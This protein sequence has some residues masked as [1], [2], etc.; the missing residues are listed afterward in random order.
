MACKTPKGAWDILKEEFG[1]I[2]KIKLLG[3][4]LT[5]KR[6]V[7][8]VLISLPERFEAKISSLEDSKNLSQI[9]LAELVHSL[10]AQEQRGL[11]RQEDSHDVAMVASQKGRVYQREDKKYVGEKKGK[12][13]SIYQGGKRGGMRSFPP[14]SHYKKRNNSESRCWFRPGIQ[15]RSCK[16]F[17]HIEK[18]CKNKGNQREQQAQVVKIQQPSSE[19]EQVFMAS[20]SNQ[21]MCGDFSLIDSGCTNHMTPNLASFVSIGEFYQSRVKI[22]NGGFVEVKGRGE[23]AIPTPSGTKYISNVLYVPEI[24]QSLLSVGQM[25]EKNYSLHFQNM[26]CIVVEVLVMN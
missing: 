22:G 10:Q 4:E 16:Q 24:N 18:V 12:E 3:E 11:P 15:C 7:E 9:S 5:N 19:A 14:C 2:N 13:K 21:K 26:L 1:R 23:V 8:K 25:L 17:G 20:C 6:I